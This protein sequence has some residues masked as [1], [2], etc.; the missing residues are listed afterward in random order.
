MD[1]F[2]RRIYPKLFNPVQSIAGP[3]GLEHGAHGRY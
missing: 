1:Y 2:D 3:E